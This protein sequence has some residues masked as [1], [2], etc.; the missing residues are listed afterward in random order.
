MAITARTMAV[1]M[2][3]ESATSMVVISGVMLVMMVVIV[4]RV[5]QQY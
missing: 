3:F 5:I 2:R 1:E 4:A